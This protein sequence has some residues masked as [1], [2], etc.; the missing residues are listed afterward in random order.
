LN[1]ALPRSPA[2][3]YNP[4]MVAVMITL[5]PLME[6]LD[7]TIANVSLPHIAGSLGVSQSE[8]TWVL[9]SYLVSN[10]II[11]PISGWLSN[12]MGRKRFFQISTVLF[13]LS[14]VL[15]ATSTSL[16]M[17]VVARALQGLGGGGLAP[18]AQAMMADSFVPEKRPQVFA[19]FGFTVIVAPAT[20][21]VLG[22]WLTDAFSWHWIFLINLPIGLIAFTLT[23]IFVTEPKILRDERK[24]LLGGGNFTLDYVGLALV[25]IGFAA[26]QMFLDKFEIDDGF[27]ST[28]IITSFAIAIASLSFLV[29]WEWQNEHP[30]VNVRLLFTR[31]FG[32]CCIVSFTISFC[33][34]SST[35]LLPQMAQTLLGYTSQT[36]GLSLALGGMVTLC[37]M[38][39][40]AF[41]TG[42][43]V[44]P[45]YLMAGGLIQMGV[46]LIS[47]SHFSPYMSFDQLTMARVMQVFAMP[48]IFIPMGASS[49]IG[50][51]PKLFGDA[52]A[53]SNQMRNIGGSMGISF[54]TNMLT[55]RSQFH[56]AR[57]TEAINPY[58]AL[59]SNMTLPQ[60]DQAIQFQ[61]DFISYL[62]VF[63]ILGILALVVWPIALFLKPPP[64]QRAV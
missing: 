12:I 7:T 20:G 46:A 39:V 15:C 11:L 62:D 14:S 36:S 41:V 59:P 2:G 29:L 25:A 48:F 4:W 6:V 43:V 18:V 55:M 57:L 42:R 13:V 28:F 8:S 10:S 33:F 5:A 31:N 47:D 40:A 16:T 37:F 19:L 49:F 61:A 24:A 63:H 50:V 3:P 38:P 17:L 34:L 9:T 51:N 58:H 23:S 64:P 22:G 45:R 54:A 60:L 53:L 32:I 56:H 30:V 1:P 35:Q 26:L 27:S 21:P 44:A 52:A